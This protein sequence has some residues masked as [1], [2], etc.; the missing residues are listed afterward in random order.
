MGL[1]FLGIGTTRSG[2]TFLHERLR[3]HP[4]VWLPPQKE[5]HYFTFQRTGG[6]WNRRHL[7]HLVRA[8]P[9]LRRALR[10]RSNLAAELRWQLRYFFGPRNDRWY[11]SLYETPA[12]SGVAGQIEPTYA[13][14][15]LR[16]IRVVHRL[17]PEVKLLYMMRDPIERAWSSATKSTAKNQGRPMVEVSDE[18]ILAKLERSAVEMSTYIEHIERWE[19]VFPAESFFFGFY[20][21]L[22]E[23]PE[24]LLDRV[25]HFVGVSPQGDLTD[26]AREPVNHTRHWKVAIPSHIERYLAERLLEPTRALADRFGGYTWGWVERME[27]ALSSP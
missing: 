21:D 20:D 4:Q 8:V 1:E 18:E 19:K 14:L 7:K 9:N 15:P 2:T 11:L 25:A 24:R 17:H 12:C 26:Q 13:T 16:T 22:V 3:A 6:Y 10:D 27:R 23:E 5:L